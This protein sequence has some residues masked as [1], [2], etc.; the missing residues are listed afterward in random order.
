MYLNNSYWPE[1]WF[2]FSFLHILANEVAVH[3]SP[4]WKCSW[5][6]LYKKCA[7]VQKIE[8]PINRSRW[9]V[10][11]EHVKIFWWSN[12]KMWRSS[13][14]KVYNTA[15]FLEI[16][17]VKFIANRPCFLKYGGY[18]ILGITVTVLY[19]MHVTVIYLMLPYFIHGLP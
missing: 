8:F 16:F 18:R 7:I 12:S 4:R 2:F 19:D 17:T 13:R 10:C 15:T 9:V 3:F 1:S 6:W 14:P 5:I 11:Q